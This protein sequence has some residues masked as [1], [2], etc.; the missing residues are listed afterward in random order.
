MIAHPRHMSGAIVPLFVNIYGSIII[1]ASVD[2]SER[3]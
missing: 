2:V 1:F 3:L